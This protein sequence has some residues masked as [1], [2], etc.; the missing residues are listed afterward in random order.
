VIFDKNDDPSKG[1]LDHKPVRK[2]P[3]PFA[4]PLAEINDDTTWDGE[5]HVLKRLDVNVGSTLKVAPGS[6]V[7][8]GR[9]SSLWAFGNFEALGTVD[10]RIRFTAMEKTDDKTYWDQLTTERASARFSNCD[11]EYAYMA[12]HVH[13]S[14][15]EIDG[16]TFRNNDSGVRFRGGP[17]EINNSLFEKNVYGMVSYL[18][19]GYIRDNIFTANETGILIR[20]ERNGGM[21]IERNNI[22]DN[23]RHNLRMGDFNPQEDITAKNN[24]WGEG[25]PKAKIFDE[26]NEPG[27][28]MAF[29]E[30]YAEKAF[31]IEIKSEK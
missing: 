31:S 3:V 23:Q 8:F 12:V 26:L 13:F 27:I 4:W 16:C 22:F 10:R 11:F 20:A 30:P 1:R 5:F 17:V 28:G 2:G 15:V 14:D 6:V 18:A 21:T 24:W 25:D 29:Y 19:R 7:K 9:K